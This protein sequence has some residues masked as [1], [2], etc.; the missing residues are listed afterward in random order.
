MI[1]TATHRVSILRGTET[2]TYGD[3]VDSNIAIR[4]GVQISIQET[5][6]RTF[7]PAEGAYRVIRSYSATVGY[8][9]DLRKDDRIR[10]PDGTIFLVVDIS[11]PLPVF[12]SKPDRTVTLSRTT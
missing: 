12:G 9:T 11:E 10:L 8:E 7:V 4:N 2:D 3:M 6:R 5:N 1:G